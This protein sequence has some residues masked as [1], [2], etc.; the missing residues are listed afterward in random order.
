MALFTRLML[1]ASLLLVSTCAQKQT[2]QN[3]ESSSST[4]APSNSGGKADAYKGRIVASAWDRKNIPE[5]ILVT[6]T[7]RDSN[8]ERSFN[9]LPL[10]GKLKTLPWTGDYWA[11]YRGGISYRWNNLDLDPDDSKRFE[12]QIGEIPGGS[13]NRLSPSEKWDLYTG[14]SNFSLTRSERRRV[15]L[16]ARKI[17]KWEGLC[18][19]WAPATVNYKNPTKP[20]TVKS[21]SGQS[22]TFYSSDIKALLTYFL[23]WDNPRNGGSGRSFS[24]FLGSRCEATL[25]EL[26]D[27]YSSL[28]GWNPMTAL[29]PYTKYLK[30]ACGDSNAGSFHLVLTNLVG[31]RKKSFMMDVTR[32]QEVWNQAVYKYESEVLETREGASSGAAEGTVREKDILSRVW[33][34]AEPSFPFSKDGIKSIDGEPIYTIDS[35]TKEKWFFYRVELDANNKII[36]GEWLKPKNYKRYFRGGLS[37]RDERFFEDRPDFLW[38]ETSPD[39]YGRF[40]KLKAIYEASIKKTEKPPFIGGRSDD[41]LM[42][43]NTGILNVTNYYTKGNTIHLVGKSRYEGGGKLIVWRRTNV[44]RTPKV[45]Y[46][47]KLEGQNFHVNFSLGRFGRFNTSIIALGLKVNGKI[48]DS[49]SYRGSDLA[50][51]FR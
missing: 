47:K 43:L 32:T 28:M 41:H 18:H 15:G 50:R 16:G 19:S 48:V 14:S 44:R 10:K 9:L 12:Y 22:I 13:V 2:P 38:D 17:P 3:K 23:H 4:L 5:N 7:S 24:S 27:A 45:V 30:G 20:V 25:K 29:R 11:S 8:L 31:K 34:I 40:S 39:F 49:I 1:L 6:K 33:Y 42:G 51:L 35:A 21:P 36:G 37:A 26:R 46:K